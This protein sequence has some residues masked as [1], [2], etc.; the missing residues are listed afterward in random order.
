MAKGHT[1]F[2]TPGLSITNQVEQVILDFQPTVL[3]IEHDQYFIDT[4]ATD[5]VVMG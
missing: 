5:V 4:V 1:I 2:E 3:F